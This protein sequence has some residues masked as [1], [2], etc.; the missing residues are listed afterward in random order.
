MARSTHRRRFFRQALGAGLGLASALAPNTFA[1]EPEPKNGKTSRE[2]AIEIDQALKANPTVYPRELVERCTAA[3][4]AECNACRSDPTI[5]EKLATLPDNTWLD[6]N[7][8]DSKGTPA[9]HHSFPRYRG[10][11]SATYDAA[12]KGVVCFAGCGAPQYSNDLW[13]YKAGANRWFEIWPNIPR[14]YRVDFRGHRPPAGCTLGLAYAAKTGRVYRFTCANTGTEGNNLWA[15]AVLGGT[16]EIVGR[17][18]NTHYEGLRIV[19][20]PVLCGLLTVDQKG[21]T[22]LFSFAERKWTA[23]GA[24]GPKPGVCY[25]MTNL[26]KAQATLLYLKGETWLFPSKD[27][28][29]QRIPTRQSPEGHYRAGITYDSANDV[30]ILGGWKTEEPSKEPDRTPGV[31]IFDPAA[32]EWTFAKPDAGPKGRYEYFAYDPEYN[33][34]VTAGNAHGIWVYRYKK[35]KT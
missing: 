26:A 12:A 6:M 31:W 11:G 21:A 16:W 4:I 22:Y 13:L 15:T 30:A 8:P 35:A 17:N 7:Q 5:V 9:N 25:P 32:R 18:P 3:A 24:E 27:K 23:L 29:W 33:V 10:E 20:D 1:V 28:R 2:I 34:V 14:N 19:E